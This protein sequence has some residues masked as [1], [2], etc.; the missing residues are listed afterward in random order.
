MDGAVTLP[1]Q[2]WKVV[3]AELAVLVALAMALV[4]GVF[5]LD[6]YGWLMA[7]QR[8][9]LPAMG[10]VERTHEVPGAP[11]VRTFESKG[12]GTPW[13][14]VHGFADQAGTWGTL[15]GMLPQDRRVVLI[16][17]PGHGDSAAPAEGPLRLT[18]EV[19]AV[20]AVL[21]DLDSEP[22]VLVG[23]SMGGWVAQLVALE[24]PE[25]VGHLVLLNSAGLD[26]PLD[27]RL[28]LATT[29]EAFVEKLDLMS[30]NPPS[31]PGFILR[32][33]AEHFA[34]QD[35]LSELFDD[36]M[37]GQN[38]TDDRLPSLNVRT[39]LVWG[40]D[41]GFFP[42]DYA[43]RLRRLIP[44]ARLVQIPSCGHAPQVDCP[45]A[46]ADILASDMTA[47]VELP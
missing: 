37:S 19:R 15:A 38:F 43:E 29:E 5:V 20:E 45:D 40:M 13:V 6:P 41:D 23:N 4:G 2:T 28:V 8:G 11:S 24:H 27:K 33:F 35:Q 22:V 21:S 9:S 7:L 44:G 47:R 42:M 12:E 14:F 46:L 31:V 18:H 1:T 17:L 26:H 16:D 30:A 34:K 10:F 32:S 39:T 3:L 36:T 25:K